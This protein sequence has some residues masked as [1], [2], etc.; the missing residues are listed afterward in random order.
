MSIQLY[1]HSKNDLEKAV[2]I[3]LLK[4]KEFR[5]PTESPDEK[6]EDLISQSEA[7]QFLHVSMPT[8]IDWRKSKDLPHYNFNGRFFYSKKEL[9]EYGK[10]RRK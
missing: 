9:L 8:I 7:A 6:L 1:S 2:E 3:I 5:L 10:S 4:A